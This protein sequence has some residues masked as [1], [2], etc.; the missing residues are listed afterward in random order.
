[1]YIWWRD[2]GLGIGLSTVIDIIPCRTSVNAGGAKSLGS[3]IIDLTSVS[4]LTHFL[5]TDKLLGYFPV[6]LDQ[7]AASGNKQDVNR[8]SGSCARA[9]ERHDPFLGGRAVAYVWGSH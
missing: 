3:Q 2:M 8:S 4:I 7:F 1:M 5:L 6:N 9:L